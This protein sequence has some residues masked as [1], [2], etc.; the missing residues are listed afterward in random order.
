M[1]QTIWTLGQAVRHFPILR[2]ECAC[3]N[4]GD[5]RTQDVAS[6]VGNERDPHSV[7]F[8]CKRCGSKAGKA[9]VSL[10]KVDYD[11]PPKAG[12]WKPVNVGRNRPT[13]WTLERFR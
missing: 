1:T 3:G 5:F 12:L 10:L 13:A 7:R 8:G 9:N 4:V 11:R 6:E 2:V